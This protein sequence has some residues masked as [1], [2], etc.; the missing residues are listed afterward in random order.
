[1]PKRFRPNDRTIRVPSYAVLLRPLSRI[2]GMIPPL[3]TRGNRPLQMTFEDQ[4]KALILFH[5]EEYESGRHLL[6]VL[7]KYVFVHKE[8]AP[9]KGIKKLS[10]FKTLNTRGLEQLLHIFHE[11]YA[12]S[13]PGISEGICGSWRAGVH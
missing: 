13:I 8:I 1:M 4:L 9:E 5:I 11:L 2:A 3:E 6:E 7:E 10:F 12:P